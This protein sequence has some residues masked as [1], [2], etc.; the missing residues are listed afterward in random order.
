MI[1]TRNPSNY[2][3]SIQMAIDEAVDGDEIIAEGKAGSTTIYP[4][5]IDFKGKAITVRSGNPLAPTD[6]IIY[7]DTT[8]IFGM[9]AEGSVVT[10]ANGEGRGSVLKGFTVGW[11]VGVNGAGIRI[12]DASPTITTASSATTRRATTA[13]ASIASSA[14]RKSPIASSATTRPSVSSPSAAA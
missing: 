4:E 9:F 13:R 8:V 1:N 11:G 7:P 14:R 12:E 5:H 6:P 2:Y 3:F 10:F